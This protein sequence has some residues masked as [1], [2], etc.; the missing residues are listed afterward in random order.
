[1]TKQMDTRTQNGNM[2]NSKA[3]LGNPHTHKAAGTIGLWSI[4]VWVNKTRSQS[5]LEDKRRACLQA[6]G[7]C[8]SSSQTVSRTISQSF[9]YCKNIVALWARMMFVWMPRAHYGKYADPRE[10]LGQKSQGVTLKNNSN[11]SHLVCVRLLR[12]VWVFTMGLRSPTEKKG[13]GPNEKSVVRSSLP[14]S[15]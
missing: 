1:M 9:I 2:L 10:R 11:T 6:V 4:G 13:K 14:D 12:A 5:R 15:H 3:T 8:C 7:G